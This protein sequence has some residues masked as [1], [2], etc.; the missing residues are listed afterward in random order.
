MY[1]Y[2][3]CTGC[4][5]LHCWRSLPVH[6]SC[7]PVTPDG[8][9]ETG[10]EC[11]PHCAT[12]KCEKENVVGMHLWTIMTTCI[13]VLVQLCTLHQHHGQHARTH[14]VTDRRDRIHQLTRSVTRRRQPRIS[15][16]RKAEAASACRA[17]VTGASSWKRATDLSA[18]CSALAPQSLSNCICSS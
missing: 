18:T 6:Q 10:P 2:S 1:V 4:I 14:Q 16:S 9:R 3:D 5:S 13:Y 17:V 15:S 12:C 11:V 7:I 8:Q